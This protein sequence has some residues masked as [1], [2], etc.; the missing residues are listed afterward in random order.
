MIIM[1]A[2]SYFI[3]YYT[4]QSMTIS[5]V[6]QRFRECKLLLEETHWV[7]V[8]D[9]NLHSSSNENGNDAPHCGLLVYI[10]FASSTTLPQVEE[11]AQ[12]L[13]NLP[14]LTSGL[15]G[16]GESSTVSIAS[17][18]Q[19]HEHLH[20]DEKESPSP[21][22]TSSSIMP[23]S[24]VIVP[25]SNLISKVKQHGKSIQYHGQ[26]QK[27]KGRHYYHYFCDCVRGRVLEM[28][29]EVTRE[30]LPEW[31]TRQRAA[32][33]AAAGRVGVGGG[34]KQE[35]I[36]AMSSSSKHQ[37]NSTQSSNSILPENL[38][39]DSAKYSSW[40]LEG[41]PT[42]DAD[43]NSLSKSAMKKLVKIYDAHCKRHAKWKKEQQ[44]QQHHPQH[45]C[46]IGKTIPIVATIT[47]AK[48]VDLSNE[49]NAD[50]TTNSSSPQPP[51]P[52]QQQWD[53]SLDPTFCHV[54]TG[55]FGKRQG[56]EFN[57]DM[58]PFVHSF[59]V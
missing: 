37:P 57:S 4:I 32:A 58:G 34:V 42:K 54:V 45:Q 17:C 6:V 22:L 39:R 27:E 46:M 35:G 24:I 11:A 49:S 5:I 25:Q 18:L 43:G 1:I 8:G 3:L 47:D 48:E 14:I 36:A 44:Q 56:L 23:C 53:E 12:T 38:F 19:Q 50:E 13:L 31:Y 7:T 15:W 40:N 10:S 20:N 21:I 9:R 55:S 33:T 30:D 16:D 2:N 29:C 59:Q 41:F 51:L 28:Q 52:S 26:I